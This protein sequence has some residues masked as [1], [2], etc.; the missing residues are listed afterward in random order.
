MKRL[1]VTV[2]AYN[3]AEYIKQ[4][5]DS[6]VPFEAELDVVIVNDGSTDNTAEIAQTYV[7][8]YP[9]LFR[10]INKENGGHGSAVNTGIDHAQG[11]YFYVLDSDDWLDQTA[12]RQMLDRL[13]SV[14]QSYDGVDLFIVDTVYEYAY[15]GT[16]RLLSFDKVIDSEQLT[17]FSS[18]KKMSVEQYVTMHCLIYRTALLKECEVRLPEHC[19]YVDNILAYC[20]LPW[21]KKI[22][23]YPVPL[24]RY[25]IGR[26]DQSVNTD[27]MI[28][29]IDQ[30]IH[31]TKL[32][33]DW[34]PLDQ[35]EMDPD[36]RK[37]MIHYFSMMM[38]ISSVFLILSKEKAN[39]KKK[40]ALWSW[41]KAHHPYLY[42]QAKKAPLN[43]V[44]SIPGKLNTGI[45]AL[46]YKI[47]RRIY[48]FS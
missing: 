14:S 15:N 3:S 4:S 46:T 2:P 12:M 13:A 1:T 42:K 37:Y 16:S 41:L 48:R 39:L 18:F 7:D 17:N 6:L 25:F 34:V 10:L 36:L 43:T 40:D 9:S 30:Q 35:P 19:F 8:R 32:M 20:P 21:V 29:R 38:T 31:V 23:Y 11:E 24:Y 22:Y 47:A 33:A 27:V 45:V 5:L 44:V 28:K 26:A